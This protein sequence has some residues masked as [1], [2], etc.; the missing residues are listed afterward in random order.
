[1]SELFK[2]VLILA[3][4]G[5]GTRIAGQDN[6]PYEGSGNHRFQSKMSLVKGMSWPEI[7]KTCWVSPS[8]SINL[9][10]GCYPTYSFPTI[11]E[12]IADRDTDVDDYRFS[13]F[14]EK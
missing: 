13:S 1:M 5:R 8:H 9:T 4:R 12:A 3:K 11:G 7:R 14:F 2:E 10:R 6:P